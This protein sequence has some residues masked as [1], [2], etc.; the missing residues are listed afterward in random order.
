MN[1][2]KKAAPPPFDSLFSR[3]LGP[4]VN[5]QE[6]TPVPE[7]TSLGKCGDETTRQGLAFPLNRTYQISYSHAKSPYAASISVC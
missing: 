6:A 1:Q 3:V 7:E 5:K 2:P 4:P